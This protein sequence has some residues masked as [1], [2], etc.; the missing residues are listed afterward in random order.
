MN[1]LPPLWYWVETNREVDQF[2]AVIPAEWV[3]DLRKHY[4]GVRPPFEHKDKHGRLRMAKQWCKP[5]AHTILDILKEV[6]LEKQY[7]EGYRPL[8]GVEKRSIL[9]RVA[10]VASLFA[11]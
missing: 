4:Q 8:S 6:G 11:Y 1:T 2:Q 9:K 7:D 3:A 10:Y 5:E